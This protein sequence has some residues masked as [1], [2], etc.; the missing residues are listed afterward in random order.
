LLVF[1]PAGSESNGQKDNDYG[2]VHCLGP[3][4]FEHR[5]SL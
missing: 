3:V 5:M 1:R 4:V 2:K